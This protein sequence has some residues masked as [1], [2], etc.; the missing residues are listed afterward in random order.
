[1]KSTRYG[2][3]LGTL[4]KNVKSQSFDSFKKKKMLAKITRKLKNKQTD[5]EAGNLTFFA[6]MLKFSC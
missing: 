6:F 2:S 4:I 5:K 1:M 3:I